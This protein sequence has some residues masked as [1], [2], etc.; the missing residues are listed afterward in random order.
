[1]SQILTD[2]LIPGLVAVS[3]NTAYYKRCFCVILS[4]MLEISQI[5][6]LAELARLQLGKD[7]L[8][9]LCQDTDSILGFV[10]QIEQAVGEYKPEAGEVFNV[11]R[12]DMEPH[13]GGVYTDALLAEAPRREGKY[14]KVKKIL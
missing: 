7:E 10:A 4:P 3:T 14:L 11:L 6:R 13:Q 9:A 12:E 2:L 1:M 5:K 8:E